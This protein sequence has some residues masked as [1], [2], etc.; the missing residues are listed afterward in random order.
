MTSPVIQVKGNLFGIQIFITYKLGGNL[1]DDRKIPT[2]NT[3]SFLPEVS[4]YSWHGKRKRLPETRKVINKNPGALQRWSKGA[5]RS[6]A[7]SNDFT[8][9]ALGWEQMEPRWVI[10]RH[11]GLT[12]ICQANRREG[13]ERERGIENAT[14]LCFMEGFGQW[15]TG[16]AVRPKAML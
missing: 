1:L 9:L 10:K 3:P 6:T 16:L 13:A 12:G 5:G 15:G 8:C 7:T 14:L 2:F 11:P 4:R